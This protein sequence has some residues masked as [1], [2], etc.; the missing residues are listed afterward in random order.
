MQVNPEKINAIIQ[1]YDGASYDLIPIMQDIQ[2]EFRF[3][4]REALM[5]VAA[6]LHVPLSQIYSIATFYKLFSLVP[7]GEHEIKVCLG[8]ACHLKG[9]Q[10]V[11]ET[12]SRRLGIEPGQTT[13]DLKF[14]LETVNC[15]GT[16][17]LAPVIMVDN[18]Y[19]GH[20]VASKVTKL[21]KP[22]EKSD[23]EK[24]DAED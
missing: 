11:A 8:T 21:L 3:L 12:L 23:Q 16:C 18:K 10:R 6:Q 20:V 5:T 2:D 19:H 22:Y 14:T 4:P 9:G 17:A 1:R 7:R 15:L 13:K 24:S